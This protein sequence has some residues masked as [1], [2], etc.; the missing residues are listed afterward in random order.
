[1][2]GVIALK[3]INREGERFEGHAALTEQ[4]QFASDRSRD[5]FVVECNDRLRRTAL[6][7]NDIS[8][9]PLNGSPLRLDSVGNVT[10]RPRD[11]LRDEVAFGQYTTQSS[12]GTST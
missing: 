4:A 5:F 1:M 8:E 6:V 9:Q 10:L 3:E 11:L 7:C 12:L 2:I